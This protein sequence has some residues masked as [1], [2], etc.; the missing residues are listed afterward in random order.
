VARQNPAVPSS[1]LNPEW[2]FFVKLRDAG[3]QSTQG[4][5]AE[6]YDEIGV[7]GTFDVR[8]IL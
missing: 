3:R 5:L 4:W 2:K 1:R 6:H 8:D 7:R